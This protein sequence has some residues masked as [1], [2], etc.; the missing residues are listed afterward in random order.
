MK[1]QFTTDTAKVID[2]L[3]EFGAEDVLVD[4]STRVTMTDAAGATIQKMC[5]ISLTFTEQQ[6]PTVSRLMEH[7]LAPVEDD[8]RPTRVRNVMAKNVSLDDMVEF[9]V[10]GYKAVGRVEQWVEA[11]GQVWIK[12]PN[13]PGRYFL[14]DE[15]VRVLP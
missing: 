7:F 6:W 10:D 1:L 15:K 5:D 8:Q 12:V 11:D 9:W 13:K 2:V 14:R 4:I 3:S